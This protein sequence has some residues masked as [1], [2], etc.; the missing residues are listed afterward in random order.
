MFIVCDQIVGNLIYYRYMNPAIVAP[1]GFDVV[2]LGAG[3]ALLPGQRRTLGSIARILQHSAALKH[4]HGD[5]AHLRALN[6]YIT[7]THSR[8]R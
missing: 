2:E 6:E 8:F 4:F 7:H 1:D 5:S 3:S